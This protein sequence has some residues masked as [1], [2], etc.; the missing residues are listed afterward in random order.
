MINKQLDKGDKMSK[1]IND[2]SKE[3]LMKIT[4]EKLKTDYNGFLESDWDVVEKLLKSGVIDD[5]N[6]KDWYEY[7][8]NSGDK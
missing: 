8:N 6:V 4:K 1:E 7:R 2:L 3:E 5:D